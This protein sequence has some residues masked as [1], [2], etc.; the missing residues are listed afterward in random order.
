MLPTIFLFVCLAALA[1]CHQ[2]GLDTF[3]NP[4]AVSEGKIFDKGSSFHLAAGYASLVFFTD[5][6][7]LL[8]KSAYLNFKGKSREAATVLTKG[9]PLESL[10]LNELIHLAQVISQCFSKQE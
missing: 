10:S 1:S 7:E 4:R 5:G 9:R 3:F 8:A 2:D 6:K